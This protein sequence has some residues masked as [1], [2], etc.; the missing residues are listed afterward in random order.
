M[1]YLEGFLNRV[2][3]IGALD[4]IRCFAVLL[5]I[6]FHAN[7]IWP[8]VRKSIF[9]VIDSGFIGVDIFFV[10]SG[11]LIS[12]LLLSEFQQ[13]GKI[14]FSKF[15][16]RRILR[17][18]PPMAICLAVTLAWVISQGNDI[19]EFLIGI[20]GAIFN[21]FN[22]LVILK[23]NYPELLG[24]LWSLSVEEQ[25]YVLVAI[26]FLLISKSGLKTKL[27]VV[28]FWTSLLLIA[29]SVFSRFAAVLAGWG[30]E[31]SWESLHFRTDFRFAEF[32]FGVVAQLYK[33]KHKD[34]QTT[35]LKVMQ[36]PAI[37]FLI[38]YATQASLN[39]NFYY[40]YGSP[41]LSLSC[42]CVI[43]SS[44]YEESPLCRF[45]SL[46]VFRSIG[47]ISYSMYLIH[48]PIFIILSQLSL[49]GPYK[50]LVAMV[51]VFIYS[52][53]IFFLVEKPLERF[54]HKYLSNYFA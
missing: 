53:I 54:R 10:L 34:V 46:R 24:H 14:R 8:S 52:I 2:E 17:L 19:Q 47:R 21:Y 29:W 41:I 12:G 33:S 5:A 28:L 26:V 49:S 50:F 43:L 44:T 18:L 31:L 22:W 3:R 30:P 4:G 25:L 9:P 15:F 39:T 32:F 37:L 20:F 27:P 36:Y 45:F 13:T 11:F 7:T 48:L 23:I 1:G 35:I 38:Y 40:L 16:V 42:A 51:F 6:G